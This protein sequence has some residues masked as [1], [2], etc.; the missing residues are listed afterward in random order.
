M[1]SENKTVRLRPHHLLCLLHY[2]GRG[3]DEAF[4]AQMD[5]LSNDLRERPETEIVLRPGADCLC[6]HC[7]NLLCGVCTS[8]KPDRYDAAVTRLCGL[9]DGEAISWQKAAEDVRENIIGHGLMKEVCGDCEWAEL[10]QKSDRK[11]KCGGD[12][13]T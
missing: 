6:E 8:G 2:T 12:M 11:T 4:T 3:Y 13:A 10:C 9:Y 7:P 5:R 1:K